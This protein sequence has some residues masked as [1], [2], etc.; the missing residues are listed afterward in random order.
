MANPTP[1]RSHK[2]AR[3][4]RIERPRN[5]K[6]RHH[7]AAFFIFAG[8]RVLSWTWRMRLVDAHGTFQKPIGPV[9][10]CMWH[11]RL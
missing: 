6:W 8:L 10:F 4:K 1:A 5:L 2:D 11:N 3:A 7:A 9:I